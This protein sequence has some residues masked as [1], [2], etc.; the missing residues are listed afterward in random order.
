MCHKG[1]KIELNS[2]IWLVTI[3]VKV[4]PLVLH[5]QDLIYVLLITLYW[6]E[7][8]FR[9]SWITHACKPSTWQAGAGKNLSLKTVSSRIAKAIIWKNSVIK[10]QQWISKINEYKKFKRMSRTIFKNLIHYIAIPCQEK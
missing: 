4:A 5:A 7:L 1:N 8:Y 9:S 6:I 2:S 10:S 3:Y